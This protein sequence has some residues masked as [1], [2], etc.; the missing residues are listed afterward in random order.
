VPKYDHVAP[1]GA[2]AGSVSFWVAGIVVGAAVVVVVSLAVVAG[3]LVVVVAGVVV[4]AAASVVSGVVFS[5]AS[6]P[7]RSNTA[8]VSEAS[9]RTDRERIIRTPS[10]RHHGD[11]RSRSLV[12]FLGGFF[13][14]Q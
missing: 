9:Q 12:C 6:H 10:H 2:S 4:V 8:V 13:E 5:V 14:H 1:I 3:T 11:G 7:G